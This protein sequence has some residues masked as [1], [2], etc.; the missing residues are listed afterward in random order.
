MTE[1]QV[2]D[3]L[4]R[5]VEKEPSLMLEVI[6]PRQ[7]EQ[8]ASTSDEPRGSEPTGDDIPWCYCSFC[9]EM[10]QPEENLC[11]GKQPGSSISRLA[12]NLKSTC[13]Q[14]I[15]CNDS[16]LEHLN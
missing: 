14:E 15:V 7:I 12:I 13:F 11:C 1:D 8:V 5:T 3:L 6:N 10:P 4:L 16:D 9:R 2:R